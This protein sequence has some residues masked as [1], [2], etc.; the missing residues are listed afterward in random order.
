MCNSYWD[1]GASGGLAGLVLPLSRMSCN[2]DSEPDRV[3]PLEGISF[4]DRESLRWAKLGHPCRVL[5]FR[6]PCPRIWEDGNLSLPHEPWEMPTLWKNFHSVIDIAFHIC[7]GRVKVLSKETGQKLYREYED[8]YL[9]K[10]DLTFY[11]G[12]AHENRI[13]TCDETYMKKMFDYYNL[14][15]EEVEAYLSRTKEYYNKR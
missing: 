12:Y 6:K 10:S 14:E 13:L 2:R 15:G 1:V 3:F 4:V 11:H 9:D 8:N 7:N 5:N